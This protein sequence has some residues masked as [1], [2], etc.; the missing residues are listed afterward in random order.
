MNR[1]NYKNTQE[2][3]ILERM[4][5]LREQRNLIK[6]LHCIHEDDSV[7]KKEPRKQVHA[8]LGLSTDAEALVHL[9]N[10]PILLADKVGQFAK[11]IE[12]PGYFGRASK[13][14]TLLQS[15]IDSGFL[16]PVENAIKEDSDKHPYYRVSDRGTDLLH[17]L[18]FL[19]IAVEKYSGI[20]LFIF[21]VLTGVI[22]PIG[23]FIY[24]HFNQP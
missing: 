9:R 13:I 11:S 24:N 19:Q 10:H 1:Y 8:F 16:I 18:G 7:A 15:C 2:L 22:V 6:T 20:R 17:F 3:S 21:G 14:A 23:L 4:A 12:E 5:L